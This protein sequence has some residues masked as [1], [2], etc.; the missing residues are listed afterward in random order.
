MLS[1]AAR[2]ILTVYERATAADLEQ[3]LQWYSRAEQLAEALA[4]GTPYSTRQTAGVIAALS[5]RMSWPVNVGAA[6][7][8]VNAAAR[9]REDAP[10]VAGFEAN[11]EKAWAILTDGYDNPLD[12]LGGPKVTSFYRNLI[13]DLDAVTVDVWAARAAGEDRGSFTPKQYER[14]ADAYREVAKLL[15]IPPRNVQAAVWVTIRRETLR[16][17]VRHFW[18]LD[19]KDFE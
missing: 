8:L 2:N 1:D 5:P 19:R 13:G 16:D 11:R 4:A 7:T 6:T 3:G 14:I 10:L 9:G 18:I 17:S 15:D 12:V